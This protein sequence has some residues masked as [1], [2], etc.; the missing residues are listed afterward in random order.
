MGASFGRGGATTFQQDLVNSDCIVIQGSNMAECHPVGFQWVMEAKARGAKVFHID[1]R[2]TRTS[3]MADAHLPIRAGSDIVLLGA[4]I[5]HVLK[6]AHDFREYVL[7]YTNAATIIS[8][9]F[10]DTEDLDGLFSGFQADNA[11]YDPASWSYEGEDAPREREEHAR[12][13]RVHA[14]AASADQYGSGGPSAHPTP[15]TD[16]TLTHRRCVYQLLAHH[17]ARYTPKLVEELCGIP[18]ADFQRLADAIVANSGRDRTT[19]WVYSVGWTQHTVGAQYIRAASI[20]QLLLGNIGRPGGGIL[21][22][23]GHASIQGSTDIPTLFNILPGY[24]PMPHAELHETLEDYLG[25]AA[26][27]TGFWG[28]KRSYMVSL[29]KAWWGDSATADN[30]FRFDYMPRITGDHGTYATVFG[31]IDGTVKGYFVIGENPVVGSAGGRAQRLGLANLDWLVVRDLVPIET[32]T[33]WKDGPEIETGELRTADIGTE[34]FFLPAASHVEKEGTFTQTQRL[35]Q[36]REK[37]VDPPGDCRSDLWFYYHLG[38]LLRERAGDTEMDAPLRDLT[39]DYPEEGEHAEPSAEAVLREING[40]GPDGRA[41]SSYLELAADGSTR[42]GCWIY[43]GVF[44]DEVNQ[45]ARRKPGREQSLVAP[46][47]GWA[48][49]LNRRILYNRASADPQGR[50]WSER[51]SYIVWDPER[52][53]W[54]G[55]DVPDFEKDKPPDYVPPPGATAQAAIAGDSPFIMQTDG[56]GWLFAPAGLADGPLPTHYEPDESPVPNTLYGTRANPAR[57]IYRRADNPANG[58]RFPYVLTTYRLTEHHTAGGMSRSLAHLA[59]L[60]PEMFCEVSP[61]LAAELGLGNGGWA[62]II[63]SRA[64][65]E[66]RVLVSER[67]RPL[68]VAGRTVH[69]IGVPYHWGWAGGGLVTGDAANDLLGVVLDPNVYIQESKAATCDVLPGRRPRGAALRALIEEYRRE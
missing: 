7:A 69:Q 55:P 6:G 65:I 50:P 48:W 22:L 62:T 10:R 43:C 15:H 5:N 60:Q 20:L 23:R 27:D 28:N 25:Y 34:V 39:W 13:G 24:M 12:G 41:L 29:L 54:T 32:A 46:E 11:S 66:A 9:D 1:P 21:A 8:E 37:A 19:A 57:K 36:W 35:L 67:V 18:R 56:K 26:G 51:K 68:R 16:P 4:L 42:C 52:R 44:A 2:F 31:Q 59:E 64:A 3:A 58:T 49:P 40:T 38:K 63:T 30:D 33:F 61:Q 47:W 17:F 45:A 53:E 14:G